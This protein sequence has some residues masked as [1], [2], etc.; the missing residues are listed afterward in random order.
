[1]LPKIKRYINK[2]KK[3]VKTGVLIFLAVL[4]LLFLYKSFFYS[5]SEKAVY[6]VR[7]KDLKKYEF[8]SKEQS[9]VQT[10]TSKIDGVKDARII[11]K[12]RIIKVFITFKEDVTT[13]DMKT[14]FTS[15]LDSISDKVK[16]YYDVTFYAIQMKDKKP[17][18]PVI[19]YKHTKN[20]EITWDVF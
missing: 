20:K 9:K 14:K 8:T 16:S 10:S 6:G 2:N 3:Q 15:V 4:I 7:L 11:V 12:G 18:Y 19:G 17:T 1:M 13:D 5:S